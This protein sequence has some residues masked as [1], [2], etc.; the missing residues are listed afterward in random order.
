MNRILFNLMSVCYNIDGAWELPRLFSIYW[1]RSGFDRGRLSS[2]CTS[3]LRL[4]K[5]YTPITGKNEDY[6]LAAA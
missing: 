1:G 4:V 3:R 5:R 2:G 6:A